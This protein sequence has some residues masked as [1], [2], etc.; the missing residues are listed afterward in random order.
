MHATPAIEH[1]FVK[2]RL[3]EIESTIRTSRAQGM[4]TMDDNLLEL[5][6]NGMITKESCL[7]YAQDMT[8]MKK[9][10]M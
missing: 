4:V 8:T 5:Y 10:L 7:S 1:R 3:I 2:L 9:N 6:R